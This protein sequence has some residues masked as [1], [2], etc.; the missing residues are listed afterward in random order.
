MCFEVS[1]DL[2]CSVGRKLNSQRT[3][4]IQFLRGEPPHCVWTTRVHTHLPGIIHTQQGGGWTLS[5]PDVGWSSTLYSERHWT[6]PHP[7][8]CPG[9]PDLS[10]GGE[11]DNPFGGI[12][13]SLVLKMSCIIWH[14]M[15]ASPTHYDIMKCVCSVFQ[16][17]SSRD[18]RARISCA[19]T[20]FARFSSY[21]LQV[22]CQLPALCY[23]CT[24]M[25]RRRTP[26]NSYWYVYSNFLHKKKTFQ[27]NMKQC[28]QNSTHRIKKHHAKHTMMYF[29][30]QIN[31]RERTSLQ[32]RTCPIDLSLSLKRSV[33]NVHS[34]WHLQPGME[35]VWPSTHISVVQQ[36]CLSPLQCILHSGYTFPDK[37]KCDPHTQPKVCNFLLTFCGN[38]TCN[39][40]L[41]TLEKNEHF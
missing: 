38:D 34:Q 31:Q 26:N 10:R 29:L 7:I 28:D 5:R 15:K 41:E 30:N 16:Q 39:S 33:C 18:A 32:T 11:L 12:L 19:W 24:S 1:M 13:Q 8:S 14:S 20:I 6:R 27:K 21:V 23:S 37:L 2:P 4:V 40:F 17:R 36:C 35:R 3:D 22:A 9:K 25:T